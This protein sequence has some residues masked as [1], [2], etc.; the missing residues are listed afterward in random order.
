[1]GGRNNVQT[2][3][4]TADETAKPQQ[5]LPALYAQT[6]GGSSVHFSG[7]FWRQHEIDFQERSKVGAIAGTAF[8]DWPITY[9]DLEPYYT[10]VDWEIGLS[11]TPETSVA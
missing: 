8:D 9:A 7:N 4:R 10:R 2:Y 11:G 1:M 6:V 3:R 5:T